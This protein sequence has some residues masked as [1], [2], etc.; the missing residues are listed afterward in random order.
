MHKQTHPF[1]SDSDAV[2]IRWQ[3]N[4][5]EEVLATHNFIVKECMSMQK[6][7]DRK[8]H[9]GRRSSPV[10]ELE[11][12]FNGWVRWLR[13]ITKVDKDSLITRSVEP[14]VDLEK[15]SIGHRCNSGRQWDDE[16]RWSDD[17]GGSAKVIR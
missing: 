14:K 2:F 10:P 12:G 15:E 8:N 6:S 9:Q 1:T 3:A 11:Q 13:S 17:G 4:P 5:L 7:D 16:G